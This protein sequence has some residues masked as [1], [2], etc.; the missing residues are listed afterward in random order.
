MYSHDGPQT[1]A[2]TPGAVLRLALPEDARVTSALMSK[3]HGIT[4]E[5][6]IRKILRAHFTAGQAEDIQI[7]Y[8][9]R[10]LALFLDI[11]SNRC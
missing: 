2:E 6:Q 1:R 7:Q 9:A 3:L 5:A 8:A 4:D 11:E 10:E